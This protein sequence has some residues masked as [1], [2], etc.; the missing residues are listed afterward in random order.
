MIHKGSVRRIA[1]KDNSTQLVHK[2]RF[3]LICTCVLE[4]HKYKLNENDN[5]NNVD[6]VCHAAHNFT[7]G[8]TARVRTHVEC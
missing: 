3:H 1:S 7:D 8:E 2:N 4:V 5:E 6:V